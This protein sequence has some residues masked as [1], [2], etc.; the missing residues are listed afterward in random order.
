[1]I[2]HGL[3]TSSNDINSI[4]NQMQWTGS[5][6]T[7][8][9]EQFDT[10]LKQLDNEISRIDSFNRALELLDEMLEIDKN[11]NTLRSSLRTASADETDQSIISAINSYNSYIYRKIEILTEERQT[12]R[13]QIVSILS[14]F[15]I[16]SDLS[17]ILIPNLEGAKILKEYEDGYLYEFQTEAGL[18]YEIYVPKTYTSETKFVIYDAG[19]S[20]SNPYGNSQNNWNL[21]LDRFEEGDVNTIILR[22][23]RKDT[24]SCYED[25]IVKLNLPNTTPIAISHSGGTSK[26]S[27]MEYNDLMEAG[28][29]DKGLFVAMDGYSPGAYWKNQ[30]YLDNFAE[31]N[32]VVIG[33]AQGNDGGNYGQ[34][35]KDLA[36]LYPNTLILYDK[37]EFGRSHGSVNASLTQNDILKYFTGEKVLPDNYEIIRY[38]PQNPQCDKQGFVTVDYNDVNTIEKVYELFGIN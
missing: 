12:I 16:Q 35:Q 1:M 30:G 3:T 37:S 21:F 11:I 14:T 36:K 27:I 31:N 13:R 33:I 26:P 23:K 2:E 6:Q 15:D 20:S 32:V 24:S 38:D 25:A 28:M 4:K 7:N 10:C 34:T 5:A 8:I 19:D 22:S 9:N 18:P 17:V 29:V